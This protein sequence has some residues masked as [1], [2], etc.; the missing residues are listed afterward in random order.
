[1]IPSPKVILI[2]ASNVGL[3][4][5][6]GIATRYGVKGPGIESHWGRNFQSPSR[7]TL[8][9]IQPL[10]NGCRVISE[11]KRPGRGVHHLPPSSAEVK[12][13]VELGLYSTSGSSWQ[14]IGLIYFFYFT[15]VH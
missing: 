14:V 13:R 10:Y 5:S 3:D 4:S 7:P 2:Y 12:A 15:S 1:V 8:E 6:V 11:D 9:P